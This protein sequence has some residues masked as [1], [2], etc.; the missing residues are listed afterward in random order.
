MEAEYL[1]EAFLRSCAAALEVCSPFDT[2][3]PQLEAGS[4]PLRGMEIGILI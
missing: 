4:N 1:T 3:H 2:A